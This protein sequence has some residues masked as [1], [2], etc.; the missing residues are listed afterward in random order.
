M[1]IRKP[2]RWYRD[3]DTFEITE[4]H[5]KL[6]AVLNVAWQ[7]DTEWGA[8]EFGD[9]K[10]PFGNSDMPR[11]V[12]DI[13]DWEYDEDVGLTVEQRDRAM[14]LHFE[15]GYVARLLLAAFTSSSFGVRIPLGTETYDALPMRLKPSFIRVGLFPDDQQDD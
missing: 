13:L 9:A 15:M 10:R 6:A 11:D 3:F 8:V 14:E 12:A 5:R 2:D 4:E 1:A 7:P